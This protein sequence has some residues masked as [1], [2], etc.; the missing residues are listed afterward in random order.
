MYFNNM[1]KAILSNW[2]SAKS[3]IIDNTI[4]PS[5]KKKY[6]RLND[7]WWTSVLH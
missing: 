7:V 4:N 3:T 1:K 6:E 5:L 2:E